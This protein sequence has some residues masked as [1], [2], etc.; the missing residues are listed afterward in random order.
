MIEN[1]PATAWLQVERITDGRVDLVE[2]VPAEIDG[3]KFRRHEVFADDSW[4][5]MTADEILAFKA[6]PYCYG[7]G[8]IKANA[9]QIESAERFIQKAN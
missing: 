2:Y 1:R 6:Q 9:A 8:F 3:W 7:Q 4:P 5:N